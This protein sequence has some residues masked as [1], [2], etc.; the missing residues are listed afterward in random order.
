MAS[1]RAPASILEVP[2]LDFGGPEAPF[3]LPFTLHL[4]FPWEPWASEKPG[5]SV[6]N[7]VIFGGLTPPRRSLFACLD[8]GCVL[9]IGFSI[10]F[11]DFGLV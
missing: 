9:I 6:V 8:R 1:W 10:D 5:E 11:C 4:G 3:R 2:S 7:H